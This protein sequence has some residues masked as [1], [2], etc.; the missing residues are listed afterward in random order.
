MTNTGA[1]AGAAVSSDKFKLLAL[2]VEQEENSVTKA[3][4]L[5]RALKATRG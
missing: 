2:L 1:L 5:N 3:I 4:K